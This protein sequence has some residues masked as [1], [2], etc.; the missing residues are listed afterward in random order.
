MKD[1]CTNYISRRK[2]RSPNKGF[3]SYHEIVRARD[4][5]AEWN[6]AAFLA[7]LTYTF[8]EVNKMFGVEKAKEKLFKQFNE[9]MKLA[10]ECYNHE[11]YG[12]ELNFRSKAIHTA[13]IMYEL[14]DDRTLLDEIL[15]EYIE[16]KSS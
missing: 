9:E 5:G 7:F 4:L 15:P 12:G 1:L 10:K 2:E 13:H 16:Y 3:F 14:F 8:V 6:E 11:F